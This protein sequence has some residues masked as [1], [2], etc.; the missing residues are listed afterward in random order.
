[1]PSTQI[2]GLNIGYDDVG[3]GKPL[4]LVHG[5]P[6]NRSL[7][8]P[9]VEALRGSYRVVTLD[10]P[11]FGESDVSSEPLSIRDMAI[12]VAS[13]LDQLQIERATLGGLSMGGYVVL[14]FYKE[15]AD[16]VAGLILGDTRAEADSVEA[17]LT[18]EQQARQIL[19]E[20]MNATA[21]AMLPKLLSGQTVRDRPDIVEHVRQMILRTKPEGAATALNA[22]ASRDDQTNLLFKINVPTLI[23]IG[24]EDTITPLANSE[25]VNERIS[26]SRLVKID[27]AAHVSNLEQTEVWNK[28]LLNFM[29]SN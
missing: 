21:S 1:M 19:A 2:D 3:T 23:L 26:S 16:R 18:R 27:K 22:M 4:V 6:F 24:S 13:L 5:Y 12:Y 20:G 9:Q 7:W 28:E 29:A 25:K 17:K 15:F 8:D 10:L 11:G 14:A